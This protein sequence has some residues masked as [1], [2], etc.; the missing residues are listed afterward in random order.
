M[1]TVVIPSYLYDVNP[2]TANT[3]YLI[4]IV[5]LLKIYHYQIRI[6]VMTTEANNIVAWL[7]LSDPLVSRIYQM[8]T[9]LKGCFE[10]TLLMLNKNDV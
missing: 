6:G 4:W 8:A 5:H 10:I 3:A 7:P 9:P 1:Y 2:T